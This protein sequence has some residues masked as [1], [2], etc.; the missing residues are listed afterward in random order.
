MYIL[1]TDHIS[2]VEWGSG[3]IGQRLHQRIRALPESDVVT[4]I[5][6]YEEQT[7][8]WMA[9]AAAART[10]IQQIEAYRKLQR[11]LTLYRKIEVMPFD[12]SAGDDFDRLQRLRL[13]IGTMDLKIAAI[14]FA[15]QATLLTRNFKDFSRIP[16]LPIE[17]WTT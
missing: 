12:K 13:H 15:H 7:R 9:Q 1:D 6:T 8:G 5:I 16:E 10:T 4:T 14:A 17:D 2:L 11:H 3:V